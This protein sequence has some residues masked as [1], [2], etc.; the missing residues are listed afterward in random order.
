MSYTCTYLVWEII[1]F[2][3][4]VRVAGYDPATSWFP[5]KRATRLRHT[6]SLWVQSE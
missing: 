2:P 4:M 6:L 1:L 3:K 5:T